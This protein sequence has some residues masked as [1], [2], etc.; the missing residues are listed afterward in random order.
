MHKLLNEVSIPPRLRGDVLTEVTGIPRYWV[1]V[2]ASMTGTSLAQSTQRKKLQ[3]VEDLYLHA[4]SMALPR[5]L[6]VQLT[7]EEGASLKSQTVTSNARRD[8]ARRAAMNVEIIRAL[9]R[10]RGVSSR[11]RAGSR[12]RPTAVRIGAARARSPERPRHHVLA[13]SPRTQGRWSAPP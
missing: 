4:E 2:W 10:P 13:T 12:D 9:V 7:P 3:Y 5:R 11:E 8:G 6:R 1:M